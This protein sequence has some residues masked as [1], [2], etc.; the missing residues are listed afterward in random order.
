M[1][2]SSL[3]C[4]TF[5]VLYYGAYV[6]ENSETGMK[7]ITVANL[8]AVG[9]AM[10]CKREVQVLFNNYKLVKECEQ[11]KRELK[12][13]EVVYKKCKEAV[14]VALPEQEKRLHVVDNEVSLYRSLQG[15]KCKE[16]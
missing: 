14:E 1:C 6:K 7:G 16:D 13:S 11:V 2:F 4:F 5:I 9:I 12:K 15:L 8:L 3:Y 10:F